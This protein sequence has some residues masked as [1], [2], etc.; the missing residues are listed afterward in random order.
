V[1]SVFV[2]FRLRV[3]CVSLPSP[4]QPHNEGHA[5]DVIGI[6]GGIEIV[7]ASHFAL[8][9]M[10]LGSTLLNDVGVA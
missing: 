7:A 6:A 10:I 9:W 2:N 1:L 3:S 5:V 4:A 8:E